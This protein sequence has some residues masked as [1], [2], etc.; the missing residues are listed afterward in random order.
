MKSI[1]KRDGA[2]R[3]NLFKD[4]TDQG[5]YIESFIVG[6]WI[7]HLR[8]HERFTVADREA[9][10]QAHSFQTGPHRPRVMHFVS[11]SVGE[12]KKEGSDD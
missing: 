7:E 8:Q 5:H 11:E 12:R 6:S 2:L 4:I 9:E 10:E 1:R 3:W